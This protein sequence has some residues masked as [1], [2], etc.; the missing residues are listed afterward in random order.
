MYG[1]SGGFGI[2]KGSLEIREMIEKR[3]LHQVTSPG[4]SSLFSPTRP[5]GPRPFWLTANCELIVYGATE[6][7]ASVTVQNQ[8][9]KLR[10]DGSFS[11]RFSLPDGRHTIPIEATRE[12][13][14]EKRRVTP[15]VERSTE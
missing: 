15:I 13:G 5:A 10:E 6:P 9:I 3:M 2:G 1:L 14:E 4:V 12:D 11:L 7:T 8:P